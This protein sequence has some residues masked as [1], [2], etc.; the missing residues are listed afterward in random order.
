MNKA[1]FQ[2]ISDWARVCRVALIPAVCPFGSFR[3]LGS[4]LISKRSILLTRANLPE[5]FFFRKYCRAGK[6][7]IAWK[8]A[9]ILSFVRSGSHSYF[10]FPLRWTIIENPIYPYVFG[11]SPYDRPSFS[12][13]VCSSLLNLPPTLVPQRMNFGWYWKKAQECWQVLT[14]T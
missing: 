9:L 3:F 14:F 2:N 11:Y 6:M 4:I 8:Q 13:R 12:L 5:A 1:I 10:V 7:Q